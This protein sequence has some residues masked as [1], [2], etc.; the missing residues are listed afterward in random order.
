MLNFVLGTTGVSKTKY[1]YEKM[2]TLA[3]EN[4]EKLMFIVPDQASFETEKAFLELL[5]PKLSRNIK[6]FGFS[7]LCDYVFE[8]TGNRFQSFADEGIRN[9]V[10]NLA[11]E[12]VS[13]KLD[14]FSKRSTCTDLSELMLNSI[15]EYKKC[16]IT[17]KMLYDVSEKVSDETLSKKLYETALI[18]DTYNAIME[19][20]YIDPLD[21]IAQI[22]DV[23]STNPLFSDYTIAI[24]SYYGFTAVEYDLL[25]ILMKQS[26]DMYIALCTDGSD[27]SNGDLFFVTNRTKTRLTRIA[28]S[29]D[30]KIAKPVQL[31]ENTRFISQSLKSIEENIFRLSKESIEYS[32]NSV[33]LYNAD[34]IY[35]EVDFVARN[36]RKLL[37]EDGYSYSDI[38][39]ITRNSEKYFGVLDVA[40]EKYGINYFMDKPQDIDTKP[41]IKFIMACFDVVCSGF[42][43][44]DVLALLKTGLTDISVEQIADFENY[45]FIWDINNSELFSEF[46]QNPRGFADEFKDND[47]KLLEDIES[48]RKLIVDNL[49]K[50]YFDTKD[51]T[52]LEISKALMKLIYKLH[53]RENLSLMCDKLEKEE[54][55]A[56]SQEQVRLYNI[57][58]E[59]MDKMVSVIGDY[60]ISAKRFSELL[61]ISFINTDISFI[62]HSLDE[63]D[64][65]CAD[66]SLLSEKKAV[67]VIGAIDSEFPHTPVESGI[68]SDAERALLSSY[69]IE[70]SDSVTELVPT[71]K[72]LAYKALTSA[73]EK[74]FVSYYSFSLSGDKKAPSVIFEEITDTLS[75]VKVCDTLVKTVDDSLYSEQSAFDYLVKYYKTQSAEINT[76]KEYF[77]NKDRYREILISIDNT[78]SKEPK[79]IK[80]KTLSQ[81]LFGTSMTLS[82][83]QV[84]K[85]KLC[86]FE[87]FC[88]YGLRIRERRQAKID[89]L[90][91]GTMMHY[92]L[93]NFLK[94]HKNDDFS[95]ITLEMVEKELTQLLDIYFE[96][97]MGGVK[98][99]TSRFIY[100]YKRMKKTAVSIVYRVVQEFSQSKFRPTDFELNIGDDIPCYT[101]KVN[102]NINVKIKGSIDRVDVYEENS[103][104][105]IRVVDYKTGKKQYRLSDILYGI[106]LQM[107]IYMAALNR[108]GEAYFGKNITPAGVLYMPAVSP[109]INVTE[110]EN[111]ARATSTAENKKK[112]QGIILDDIDVVKAM[113]ENLS[114]EY[115]PVKLK[116]D[117]LVGNLES[118]ATL[119]QFGALF[120]QVDNVVSEMAQ[121]LCDGDVSAVPAK[122]EY[123][124][125][126]WCLYKSVCGY[127]DTDAC[128]KIDKHDKDEVY[129]I[130]LGEGESDEE[131]VD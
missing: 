123:D 90:E 18:Y 61:H 83:S 95:A 69:Y 20:S 93:E 102:D 115:L 22:C 71:E 9:V 2:C 11:I 35:E 81:K 68:Y 15:K 70:L 51:A 80:D 23:L 16:S 1:L 82:A 4:N 127:T 72:Y 87:Y 12:Q 88:N 42:D 45:L 94:N 49:R 128:N 77:L 116:G 38:A 57:F 8:V 125:C 14:L 84:D 29:L 124:P 10:M 46:T 105:Y 6:V 28:H 52:G 63:V 73:S 75:G 106:N 50:F 110:S 76:L 17:S 54:K 65:A 40:L 27:T 39:I 59:I 56:L 19:N 33:V 92:F 100:L 109:V 101:L 67:F 58:V 89:A 7:R 98:G 41:L 60:K 120:S 126:G 86:K 26:K 91:Y 31:Y 78:L 37:I 48:T 97:H 112:M 119:E 34:S 44:E 131:R 99:K 13:D 113:D 114:G 5:G 104:K 122:G 3:R 43:R 21:S 118:L 24:D 129:R 79:T 55:T 47:I 25:G 117:I 32:D 85:F 107:L 62:P 121:T 130:L 66:R 74:L 108:N 96:T 30:V 36:I 64:V 111:L 103:K 53:I